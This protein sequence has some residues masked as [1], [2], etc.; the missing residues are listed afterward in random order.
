VGL[1]RDGQGTKN[2]VMPSMLPYSLAILSVSVANLALAAIAYLQRAKQIRGNA[3]REHQLKLAE[4]RNELAESR[5]RRL[6]DQL[7]LLA[8]IRDALCGSANGRQIATRSTLSD[9]TAAQEA[10]PPA[11]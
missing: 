1:L 5:L 8:E 4:T 2:T 11:A 6:D 9:L 10:R 3:L 7:A